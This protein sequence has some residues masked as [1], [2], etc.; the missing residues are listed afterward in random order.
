MSQVVDIKNVQSVEAKIKK[1]YAN[2]GTLCDQTPR[3]VLIVL[4]IFY[5]WRE[6]PG[7]VG[8]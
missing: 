4:Q 6:I 7:G 2:A 1:F 8:D 3:Y 5:L